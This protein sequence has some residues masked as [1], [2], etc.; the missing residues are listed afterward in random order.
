M[1]IKC[2]VCNQ[3]FNAKETKCPFCCEPQTIHAVLGRIFGRAKR[4]TA[5]ICPD[6]KCGKLNNPKNKFCA[7]CG[8]NLTL[9]EAAVQ[10]ML[11]V[12]KSWENFKDRNPHFLSNWRITH[13]VLSLF[14]LPVVYKLVQPL[15]KREWNWAILYTLA[16][17]IFCAMVVMWVVPPQKRL[18]FYRSLKPTTRLALV[19]NYLAFLLLFHAG[20]VLFT[21][22]VALIVCGVV[23]THLAVL[24]LFGHVYDWWLYAGS[25]LFGDDGDHRF[26]PTADQGRGARRN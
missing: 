23:V 17:L 6:S 14:A 19:F 8:R 10:A 7:Y 26:D 12:R 4:A 25:K 2:D 22:Q 24:I 9:S 16:M 15:I 3:E 13:L 11:G 21:E 18:L 1:N 5:L 20:V